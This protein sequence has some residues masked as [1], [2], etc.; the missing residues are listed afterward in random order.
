MAYAGDGPP[1]LLLHGYPETHLAWHRIAPVLA[2]NF[3]VVAP[4][5]RG[6]GDSAVRQ[7]G[8]DG[9]SKRAMALDQRAIMAT[10]G[11]ERFAVIGHDRGGRVAYRLALDH[12]DKVIALVSLTVIPTL[13]MW[14]RTTK[15]FAMDAYHW[16]LF[17]QPHDLPERLIGG[18]PGYFFDWT[19]ARMAR[20]PERL[21]PQ[22]VSAYRAAFLKPAVRQA[23]MNDYRAGATVDEAH[24]R[25]DHDAGRRLSCPIYV[26]WESGRYRDGN[27]PIDIW[28]RWAADV[29]GSEIDAGHC[30]PRRHPIRS[31]S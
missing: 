21:S 28:R 2:R 30:R 31:S 17:A 1:L 12:S 29:H 4:D 16:F 23:I 13:E 3:T 8:P 6:Y 22:A 15:G 19:L 7:E 26:T 14:A 24:D 27:T 9:M 5:L 25:A 11:F 10:L 20:Y 18:D